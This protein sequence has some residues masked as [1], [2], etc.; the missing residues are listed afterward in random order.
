M[1]IRLRPL[2]GLCAQ[3]EDFPAAHFTGP[4]Q[5]RAC[6]S[7]YTP[8][9]AF[10]GLMVILPLSLMKCPQI[11]LVG[12]RRGLAVGKILPVLRGQGLLM[13]ASV[14]RLI[15]PGCNSW[16]SLLALAGGAEQLLVPLGPWGMRCVV[17][18]L[19]R[20]HPLPPNPEGCDPPRR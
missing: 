3:R 2:S 10:H 18:A 15:F 1:L 8:F 14:F 16:P 17:S 20:G 19:E 13:R 7:Q 11:P 4:P 5:R 12:C 9:S 6:W